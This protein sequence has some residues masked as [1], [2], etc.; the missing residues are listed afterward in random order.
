MTVLRTAALAIIFAVIALSGAASDK[1]ATGP[2]AVRGQALAAKLC[3]NCH[4]IGEDATGRVVQPGVPS[5]PEIA[6]ARGQ[7]GDAISLA[8]INP[9]KPMPDTQLT[10]AEILHLLAYLETLRATTGESFLPPT[11]KP[12]IKPP[13]PTERSG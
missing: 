9:A 5:F 1:P 8:L 7:T 2:D 4:I 3:A 6:N 12:R 10:R 11:A 13:K